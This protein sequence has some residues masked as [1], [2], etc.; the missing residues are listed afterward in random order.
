MFRAFLV[1]SKGWC[2]RRFAGSIGGMHP[3][4]WLP[5]AAAALLILAVGGFAALWGF[6]AFRSTSEE[7]TGRPMPP[8]CAPLNPEGKEISPECPQRAT[9]TSRS[10]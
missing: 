8:V 6:G 4:R 2:A 9:P 10:P 1:G 7:A 3:N 5:L